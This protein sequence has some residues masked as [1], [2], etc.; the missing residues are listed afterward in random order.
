MLEKIADLLPKEMQGR[1]HVY[2][3]YALRARGR[4][5]IQQQLA[6]QGIGTAVHYP[7]PVHLITAYRDLGYNEEH[8]PLAKR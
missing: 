3:I 2:H 5:R 1:E 6:E 8:P 7:E 4:H